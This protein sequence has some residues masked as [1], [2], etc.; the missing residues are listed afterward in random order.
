MDIIGYSRASVIVVVS[1]NIY[2]RGVDDYQIWDN[3]LGV[4]FVVLNN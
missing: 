1:F 4:V 3:Q 2:F